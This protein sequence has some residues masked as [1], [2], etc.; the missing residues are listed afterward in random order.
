MNKLLNKI[1][2]FN[3][4]LSI[5]I[6]KGYNNNPD[7][8]SKLAQLIDE[9][10]LGK[11]SDKNTKSDEDESSSS[12]ENV[13]CS[14]SSASVCSYKSASSDN[15]AKKISFIDSGDDFIKKLLGRVDKES[16][17]STDYFDTFMTNDT[18][19]ISDI[20]IYN[21]KPEYISDLMKYI[22]KCSISLKA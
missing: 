10:E 13:S 17:K 14:S 12:D 2:D 11:L 6:A 19:N 8:L 15:S 4:Y 7:K 3:N 1:T 5:I 20:Y 21:S 16:I 22:D 18:V 9:Y